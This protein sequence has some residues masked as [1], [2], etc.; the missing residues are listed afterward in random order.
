MKEWKEAELRAEGYEIWNG[1]ITNADLDMS[2]HGCITMWLSIEGNG[3]GVCY[4]GICLGK[5]YVG[6]K[7]FSSSR[8]S[9]IYI[10][11]IMDVLGV[12]KFNNLKGQYVRVAAK[13]IGSP[14]KIIGNIIRDKWFDAD[15][16]F[17]PNDIL[18][19]YLE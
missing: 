15:S 14:V 3:C 16:C 13:S 18:K 11:R 2:D 7:T 19:E 8:N 1:K 17:E 5:G 10:M 12:S 4:G 6:A 9:M